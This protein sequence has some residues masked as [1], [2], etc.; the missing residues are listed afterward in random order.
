MKSGSKQ[1]LHRKTVKLQLL[2][3]FLLLVIAIPLWGQLPKPYLNLNNEVKFEHLSI[4]PGDVADIL[5]DSEGY[6]WFSTSNGLK[7]YDGYN[8]TTYQHDPEDSTT[9]SENF[10]NTIWE[11]KEGIIW[12]GTSEGGLSKFDRS[13]D[14]FIHFKP[15]QYKDVTDKLGHVTAIN[16][17]SHGTLW[18]GHDGGKL[19]RF[20]KKAGNFSPHDFSHMLATPADTNLGIARYISKIIKDHAGNL[21]IANNKIGIHR[22]NDTGDMASRGFPLSFTHFRKHPVGKN[23]F[24]SYLIRSI[25]Q[26]YAGM[27][28][29]CT[30]NGLNRLNPASGEVSY[31]FHDPTQ[32]NS[33][34]HNDVTDVVEDQQGNLWIATLNGLNRL[35]KERT[36]FTAYFQDPANPNSLSSNDIRSLYIDRTGIIWVITTAGIDKIY[37]NLK[38]FFLYRHIPFTTNSLS[39]NIVRCIWEDKSGI[40]WVAT[41]GGGLNAF[42]RRSGNFTHYQHNSKNPKSLP[43]DV[44]SSVMEDRDGNLWVAT[45]KRMRGTLSILNR[46]T[47]EFTHYGGDSA[48]YPNLGNYA[49]RYMYEDHQGIIWLGH[50]NG[51]S[52]FDRKT[53]LVTHFSQ[54]AT[55]PDDISGETYIIK[56]DSRGNLWVGTNDN[57]LH[58]FERNT[59]KFIHYKPDKNTP[60]SIS[61]GN[62]RSIY[63]DS[64]GMLWFGTVG[65][66]L[67]RF[68]YKTETFTAFTEKQGLPGHSVFSIQ[69]DNDGN[70]WLGTN[71]GLS[72]FNL[73]T[74]SFTNYDINDGLQ[75]N[76]FAMS[77]KETGGSFKG[78]DG[79]LYFGGINGLNIFNPRH[80]QINKNIPPIV[81]TH[82]KLF[83]KLLPGTDE[84][85]EAH[86]AYQEN[87]FSFEFAALNYIN[88]QKNQYAYKLEGIDKDWIYS[89][90]RRYVSYTNLNPGTYTFWVK[91][92]NND[93]VWNEQGDSMKITIYPP[94]WRTFWAYALYALVLVCITYGSYQ[95]L[96]TK[97]RL[98][99]DLKL[100]ELE[101]TKLQEV[102]EMK[103]R[104]FTNIS[105]EFRTPLTLILGPVHQMLSQ[106]LEERQ[107]RKNHELI[108]ANAQRLL[109]LIN[110]LLDL[111]KLEA[112]NMPLKTQ[113]ANI[114]RKIRTLLS[115]FSS[116]AESQNITLSFQASPEKIYIFFDHDKLEKIINNLLSNAFKF[117]PYGGKITIRVAAPVS[118][119]ASG[120]KEKVTQ[121]YMQEYVEIRVEDTGRGIPPEQLTKIFDRF[122]Q[123]DASS[124]RE[125]DGTGIGLALTKE[126][127]DLHTGEIKAESE[128]GKGTIFTLFLPLTVDF[129]KESQGTESFVLEKEVCGEKL[130]QQ[131]DSI[132]RDIINPSLELT[133]LSLEKRKPLPQLLVVEDN[134]D[135]ASYIKDTFEGIYTVLE[136]HNGHEGLHLAIEYIPDLVI[137]DLMMPLMDGVEL[138]TQ[139][140]TREATSHIPFILLTAKATIESKLIGLE[141]GA[142]DYITKPFHADELIVRVKNLIE[143]RKK[144]RERYGRELTFLPAVS[145]VDEKFIGKVLTIME[146]N[147]SNVDFDVEA[148]GREI[149]MSRMQLHRKLTA[150]TNQSPG[151][152]I[153]TFRLKRAEFLLCKNY[154]NISDIAF[155]VGFSSLTYFTKCFKDQYGQTPSEY[156]IHQSIPAQS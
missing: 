152:F 65:G 118:R 110:Q 38:P 121:K 100:K 145:S 54:D 57:T 66:G 68:D 61:S 151:E 28:W 30:A 132:D 50:T 56:E 39:H 86:L 8:F 146:A 101:A 139:L 140:K 58:M 103:S 4:E 75:S 156:I 134:L 44:V 19:T 129:E 51:M 130:K 64:L 5:Q 6:L 46:Q 87:F 124:T 148:F 76:L 72:K 47:G 36:E 94:W 153:R 22:L 105:H 95:Y 107:V 15:F 59:R 52:S 2:L 102:D 9:L 7:K 119:P 17:D 136:A 90:T 128:L 32:A 41:I 122:Y 60:G 24:S 1:A 45:A 125:Q 13:K 79:T 96:L 135:V 85:K 126:L 43:N 26:D 53:R 117:T 155:S 81:I 40:I 42:D 16:E 70:L 114:V 149:G 67:C 88:T 73:S 98:K 63:E 113:K 35:N 99:H 37:P 127:V 27:I 108:Y 77:G 142:D 74:F 141:T 48:L 23:P 133:T 97:E 11:D 3:A 93:G 116:L 49:I 112:G 10:L 18:L 55:N 21:W 92:S 78:K 144:L 80:I 84:L 62:V 12:I 31:F 111:S 82:F 91:G 123:V 89:G 109:E 138:C 104:F 34:S 69:P 25:Y 137:S 83:D 29:L 14:Q 143:G 131:T 20:D 115:S 154:G 106:V 147:I 33:I 71:N 120:I 150:L